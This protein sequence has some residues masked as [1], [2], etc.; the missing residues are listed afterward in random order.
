MKD[1]DLGLVGFNALAFF[2]QSWGGGGVFRL[3]DELN[4]RWKNREK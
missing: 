3:R 4:L 1:V 2:V